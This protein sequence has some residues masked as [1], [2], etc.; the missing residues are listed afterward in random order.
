MAKSRKKMEKNCTQNR[1]FGLFLLL[2]LFHFPAFAQPNPNVGA[3]L[4]QA[5]MQIG[6]QVTL[7]ITA[8]YRPPVEVKSIGFDILNREPRLE[9]L[10][11]QRF[12][13]EGEDGLR[14]AEVEIRLTSF[15]SG[16]YFIPPVPVA[17]EKNGEPDTARTNELA[18]AVKTIPGT[19]DS[20]QIQPIKGII[21]EP[22]NFRDFLPYFIGLLALLALVA[23][24]FYLRRRKQPPPPPPPPRRAP[25][26]LLALEQLGRLEKRKLWQQG[27]VKEYHSE[28]TR[29]LREYLERRY[30]I[31]A[32]ER[33]TGEILEQ[34][35]P[36]FGMDEEMKEQLRELLQTVDLVKFAK[37]QPP[38]TFHGQAMDSV[39]E[40]VNRTRRE[41]LTVEAPDEQAGQ[42]PS[43]EKNT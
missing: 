33:T 10:R 39:V 5:E 19:A 6:D 31:V 15:D 23:L 26:H 28:L 4:S 43:G 37:A 12:E 18:L 24:F 35:R 11:A 13:R 2:C 34:L 29:I 17:Y 32:L 9:V 21:E 3:A 22:P 42:E 8:S 1:L 16:Y 41:E 7:T 20:L 27:A 38:A 30:D 25:A 40:F 36:K 14:I